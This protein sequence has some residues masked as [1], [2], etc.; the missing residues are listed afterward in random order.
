[1]NMRKQFFLSQMWMLVIFIVSVSCVESMDKEI[2]REGTLLA[3][4]TIMTKTVDDQVKQSD[5]IHVLQSKGIDIESIEDITKYDIDEECYIFIVNLRG[6]HWFLISGDYATTPIL[7]E[8]FEKG[9]RLTDGN[10]RSQYLLGWFDCIGAVI[11][12][13]RSL[14]TEAVESNR[15]QWARAKNADNPSKRRQLLRDDDTTEVESILY[16]DT[17][18]YHNY[19]GLT[20]T[21]WDKLYPFNEALPLYGSGHGYAGCVDVAIAQLVYYT[22]FTFGYPNDTYESASCSQYYNAAGTPPYNYVFNT[23]STTC[24][25]QMGLTASANYN[26]PYVAALYALVA[27]NSNTA[28][29][30]QDGV[31]VGSTPITN[32]CSSLGYFSLS[33]AQD[34]IFSETRA[35]YEIR[36]NRPVLSAGGASSSSSIGHTFLVDGYRW[37]Q[38]RSTE[39]IMDMS[40]HI[41]DTI[42]SYDESLGWHINTGES[43]GGHHIWDY[44]NTYYTF[45]RRMFVG[46]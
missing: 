11:K 28:F 33:G 23:P 44:S 42:V 18:V 4:R 29:V 38:T 7:A 31:A 45:D 24:W 36:N 40:G 17:L 20:V 43:I 13:N 15:R 35:R 26:K 6:G 25:N 46:W 39:V 9:L 12:E 21:E 14:T 5:V 32:V 2:S 8:G 3:R 37:L 34:S 41:I 19:P 16:L 10:L 1:M 27:K 22:H 30:L